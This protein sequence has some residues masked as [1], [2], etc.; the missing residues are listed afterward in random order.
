[1]RTSVTALHANLRRKTQQAIIPGISIPLPNGNY[2]V[3]AF[4]PL[5]LDENASNQ[6]I[7]QAC[8]DV[9]EACVRENPA[10]WLW[11]Y[12]HWRYLPETDGEHYPA[13]AKTSARF[14]KLEESL[15]RPPAP[16]QCT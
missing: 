13:Y 6:E 3:H 5:D 8:W 15:A 16:G 11:M 1:L 14:N 10:P 2:R 12:K 7:A 9:F 4:A